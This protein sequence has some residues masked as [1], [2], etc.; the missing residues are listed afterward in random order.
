MYLLPLSGHRIVL[1]SLPKLT[2]TIPSEFQCLDH[3]LP[4]SLTPGNQWSLLYH[5]NVVF[6]GISHKWNHTIW[7][8][9]CNTLRLF[10]SLSIMPFRFIPLSSLLTLFHV[11]AVQYSNVDVP[12]SIYSL[13][14][15][16]HQV[17]VITNRVDKNFCVH[18]LC[19]HNF[20]FL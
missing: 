10:S 12:H 4:P 17:L 14:C 15:W 3:L 6:L 18:V 5:H 9:D 19:Q 7:L 1:L 2:Y 16:C 20:S 13:I 11:I 8:Y